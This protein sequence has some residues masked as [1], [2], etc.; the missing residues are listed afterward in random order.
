MNRRMMVERA[1]RI[2]KMIMNITG[3]D[4]AIPRETM[5]R[6]KKCI[7]TKAS[8]IGLSTEGYD[9]MI[10]LQRD[11]RNAMHCRQTQNCEVIK[12]KMD[13]LRSENQKKNKCGGH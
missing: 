3:Q 5:E 10:E 12:R 4:T 1:E 9:E 6:S 8:T 11:L 7:A 13:S 2:E